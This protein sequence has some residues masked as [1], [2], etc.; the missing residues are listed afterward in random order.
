M[1]CNKHTL[2]SGK[3]VYIYDNV[4]D[5]HTADK[6]EERAKWGSSYNHFVGDFKNMNPNEY[7]FDHVILFGIHG[8]EGFKIDNHAVINDFIH[9]DK[10]LKSGGSF[11][12][13]PSH[14]IDVTL[15]DGENETKISYAEFAKKSI[16]YFGET[17]NY[18]DI[19]YNKFPD[20]IIYQAL[21]R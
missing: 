16:K 9:A 6:S 8:F 21:K 14:S 5:F 15:S 2:T 11:V 13:G 18:K 7:Q 20:N 1:N 12:W 3:K 19:Y 4:F 10:L 17:F